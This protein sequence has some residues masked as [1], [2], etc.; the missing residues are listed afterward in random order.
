MLSWLVIGCVNY[1][2]FYAFSEAF[3]SMNL[4]F[5]I[6]ANKKSASGTLFYFS[7][8]FKYKSLD[9]DATAA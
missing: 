2:C 3:D 1:S 6:T 8:A 4:I 7:R 9:V 5:L